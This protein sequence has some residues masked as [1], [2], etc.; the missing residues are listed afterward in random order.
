M[1]ARGMC[2]AER[3]HSRAP[4]EHRSAGH[5]SDVGEE[6]AAH[7]DGAADD[8]AADDDDTD[9]D[10]HDD[11]AAACS[12]GC[13]GGGGRANV[14]AVFNNE[15]GTGT[16]FCFQPGT[17]VLTQ[18]VIPKSFDRLISVVSRRAIFT[19]NNVYDAGIRGY[20]T[21][22]GQHDVTVQGFVFRDFVN[23]PSTQSGAVIAGDNWT[24]SDNK[25]AF[26]AQSGVVVNTGSVLSGN[27]IHHNGR[28]GFSGGPMAGGLIE[29][30]VVSYNNTSHFDTG[31]AG[32]SKIIRSTGVTFRHNTVTDNYGMGLWTDF[33]N[34]NILYEDNILT[35][36]RECGIFHEISADAVI[37]NNV[38]NGNGRAAV[39]QSLWYGA[40]L[41]MNDSKNT[42]IYGNTITAGNHGIALT[43]TAR[44][45]G[46][47]GL[48]EIRNVNVHD[49]SI[50]MPAGGQTGL[51]GDRPARL[52]V[53]EQP[54]CQQHVLRH[55]RRRR[56]VAVGCRQRRR[57]V[58]QPR[59]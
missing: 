36:N 39:G 17:Y 22:A 21:G 49:N 31:D 19:G 12:G 11:T 26:N 46:S 57:P 27:Y 35:N 48:L 59:P 14:Q 24:I 2:A 55:Q 54:V 6:G 34:F 45:S 52:H 28:Y 42:E 20:G 50:T 4:A 32:R 58:A 1:L 23:T 5:H 8:G 15:Y 18:P 30:N 38:F 29:N 41:C 53:G 33:D 51:V 40:D 3:S 44:G 10:D 47:Y 56:F 16:T 7:D 37:R 13:V 25:F 9:T 43:D